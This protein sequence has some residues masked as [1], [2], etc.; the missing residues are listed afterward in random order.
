VRDF[1]S[2]PSLDFPVSPWLVLTWIAAAMLMLADPARAITISKG[3]YQWSELRRDMLVVEGETQE[4]NQRVVLDDRFTEW[5]DHLGHFSFRVPYLPA[6]C[7]VQLKA[8]Q[9]VRQVVIAN[10]TRTDDSAAM[11][12]EKT[13]PPAR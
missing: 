12:T 5:S 13:A 3:E 9:N 2:A 11:P 8:G 10:C 6:D 4:P 1:A 7:M